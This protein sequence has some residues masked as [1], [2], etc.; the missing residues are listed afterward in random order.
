LSRLSAAQQVGKALTLLQCQATATNLKDVVAYSVVTA[1]VSNS[2]L[3]ATKPICDQKTLPWIRD[4]ALA[5]LTASQL[6][7]LMNDFMDGATVDTAIDL[8][9][10][11]LG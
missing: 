2:C 11:R 10:K 6:V 1:N 9:R 3:L 4:K 7:V 5:V 8:S